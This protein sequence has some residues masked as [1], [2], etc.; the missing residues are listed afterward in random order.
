MK[1]KISNTKLEGIVQIPPSKSDGQRAL[2]CAGL[3]SGESKIRNL[4]TSNDELQMLETIKAIGA[5]V[6]NNGNVFM[7][8][9]T[10]RERFDGSLF[11]GESGLGLRLTVPV[12][13][14]FSGIKIIDG[15]G[16]LKKREHSFFLQY[17]PEMGVKI[18]GEGNRLPFTLNGELCAGE[19]SVDGSYSSQYISGLLMA[20]P[21]LNRNSRLTVSSLASKQ[22]VQMTLHTLGSF[23]INISTESLEVYT[24]KGNQPYMSCDYTVESDWSSASYWLA[25]GALGHPVQLTGLSLQ[26]HQ[27]DMA[28]LSAL[29]AAG[30]KIKIEDDVLSVD[31]SELRPFSF[32]ATD[33]PDLFPALAV[34]GACAD[35]VSVLHGVRR[36]ANKE[37]DRGRVLQ[38][39]FQKLGIRIDLD[40]DIMC[41]HGEKQLSSASVDSHN[42][43]RIAM[44]LAIL[45]TRVE[46]GIEILGA[47]AVAKSYPGFWDDFNQLISSDR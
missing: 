22:Y 17:L 3:A 18:N 7:I 8:S 15:E 36:L 41:I 39:E 16:S 33:C 6:T 10:D 29:E 42:D 35:G 13:S 32:D 23:G 30:C 20:L 1:V 11:C 4:G 40:G 19:Y 12:I 45:G 38:Q 5:K 24:I 34:I 46:G 31:P 26:S 47:E 43:H 25:A 21:R 14:T 28:M 2:L 9:G 37:S 27:A 44:C